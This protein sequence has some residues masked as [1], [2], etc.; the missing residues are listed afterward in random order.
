MVG[1]DAHRAKAKR[2]RVISMM[3]TRNCSALEIFAPARDSSEFG[4]EVLGVVDQRVVV[5]ECEAAH[6]IRREPERE[7]AGVM[8]NGESDEPLVCVPSGAR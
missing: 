6:L 4:H 2:W 5:V 3:W 1:A 8:L 7:V